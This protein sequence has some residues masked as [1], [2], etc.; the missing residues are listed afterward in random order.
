MTKKYLYYGEK[1]VEEIE[2]E[3]WEW[4]VIYKDGRK[5]RQFDERGMFHRLAEIEQEH[6]DIFGLENE[7]EKRGLTIKLP[8][9]AKIIHKYRN[10]CMNFGTAQERR[11]RIYMFGFK[12][13]GESFI[14]YVMPNG[15]IMQSNDP[16]LMIGK[17][18]E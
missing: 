1:G 3:K 12:I 11:A 14:N 4:V 15:G 10:V 17:Y 9:G 7:E 18:L 2:K 13:G 16:D 5:L 6:V 8:P